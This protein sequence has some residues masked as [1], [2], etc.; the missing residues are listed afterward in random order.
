MNFINKNIVIVIKVYNIGHT[1]PKIY[2]G[3]LNNTLESVFLLSDIGHKK[4]VIKPANI[5]IITKIF[6]QQFGGRSVWIAKIFEATTAEFFEVNL[7]TLTLLK[8]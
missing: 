7:L 8:D 2:G 5:G 6:R 3:G 4:D 1:M